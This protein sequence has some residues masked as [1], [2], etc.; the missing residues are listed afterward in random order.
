VTGIHPTYGGG[1]GEA[2]KAWTFLGSF[3]K[4]VLKRRIIME[5]SGI[6][7]LRRPVTPLLSF[8]TSTFFAEDYQDIGQL[9]NEIPDSL[10]IKGVTYEDA[11][12]VL[13]DYLDILQRQNILK[14]KTRSPK[15]GR[16]VVDL[17]MRLVEPQKSLVYIVKHAVITR[18]LQRTNSMLC[19]Q[20]D[21]VECCR[22]PHDDHQDYFFE[23]PL[24]GSEMTYF[25][26]LKVDT[27]SSRSMGPF[28]EP[29]PCFDGKEF[30][31]HPPA[32][33]HWKKGW[34]L[35]LGKETYCPNLNLKKGMCTIYEK[36]PEV[37]RLPQIFPLVLDTH[38][39]PEAVAKLSGD[40]GLKRS[41]LK[42]KD[43]IYVAHNG[44]LGIL[45]C[46]YVR[47]FQSEIV[48]YAVLSGLKPFFKRGKK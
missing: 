28:A 20:Y 43:H 47:E 17:G 6:R 16:I 31:L 5:E 36:R 10:T 24:K 13:A 21:C 26:V 48:D 29:S 27:H 30:Y 37:C 22:G 8:L 35:I 4:L 15:V 33:Y 14:D 44:V 1:W 3:C 32:L 40:H 41:D 38:Y 25:N 9:M 46:P 42:D 11:K 23:L 18:E 7:L 19:S 2:N 12:Q 45:D 34:S 39:D